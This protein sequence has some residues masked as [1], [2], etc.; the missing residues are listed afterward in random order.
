MINADFEILR[1][2]AGVVKYY[3]RVC[4]HNKEFIGQPIMVGSNYCKMC[5]HFGGSSEIR[6]EFSEEVYAEGVECNLEKI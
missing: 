5:E 3:T 2:M 4:P 1:T 6:I